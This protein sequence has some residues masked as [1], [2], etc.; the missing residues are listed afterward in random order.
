MDDNPYRSPNGTS[1]TEK[2]ELLP[3]WR[4]AL[5]WVLIIFGSMYAFGSLAMLIGCVV[6]PE[7]RQDVFQSAAG[8]LLGVAML[9]GGFR[10]RRSAPPRRRHSRLRMLVLIGIALV[11]VV[12]AVG[13]QARIV[14]ERTAW[15][16]EHPRPQDEDGLLRTQRCQRLSAGNPA[17]SPSLIRR[18]LGDHAVKR[19]FVP[20]T[21]PAAEIN[22]TE[23]L[24]PEA[25]VFAIEP[26]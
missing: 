9:W 14:S 24:F 6:W 16:R 25:D 5:S 19:L 13:V 7:R 2:Q 15:L 26:D 20:I 17:R 3:F 8:F 18:W 23:S 11:G 21:M 12:F 22:L 4:R 1:E 10:M